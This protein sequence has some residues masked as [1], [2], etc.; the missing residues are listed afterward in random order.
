MSGHAHHHEED[1]TVPMK[2][3]IFLICVFV[4]IALIASL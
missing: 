4:V 2:V 3:G 1:S